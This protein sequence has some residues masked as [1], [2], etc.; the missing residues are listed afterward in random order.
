MQRCCDF[1]WHVSTPSRVRNKK[2]ASGLAIGPLYSAFIFDS[3]FYLPYASSPFPLTMSFNAT[4]AGSSSHHTASQLY[5]TLSVDYTQLN[6]FE[7][8]WMAWYLWIGNP[9]VA[10]GIASFILH[11]VRSPSPTPQ[12]KT[13]L[14]L[15]RLS[16]LVAAYRGSS[17]TQSHT[18]ASG[19][20]NQ[21][22][23]PHRRSSGSV[24]RVS[25]FPTSPL[26][27]QR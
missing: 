15:C 11:E 4:F 16:T 13:H 2:Y 23:C 10:T 22:R 20:C 8:Q 21:G 6:W 1:R 3:C 24:P 25:F 17:S 18:S 19:N 26:R 12:R 7:R 5:A 9:L 14:C 27:D